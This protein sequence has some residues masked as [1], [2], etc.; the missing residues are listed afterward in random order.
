MTS[1]NE[2]PL[3]FDQISRLTNLMIYL[4]LSTGPPAVSKPE[5]Y[6]G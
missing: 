3:S 5:I 4:D 1:K 2:D 6:L